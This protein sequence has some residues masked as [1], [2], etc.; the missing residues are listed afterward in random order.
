M[1][2]ISLRNSL[3]EALLSCQCVRQRSIRDALVEQLPDDLRTRLIRHDIDRVDV[4]SIVGRCCDWVGGLD[5]LVEAVRG[6]EGDGS[7]PFQRVYKVYSQIKAETERITISDEAER[8]MQR[9][10]GG[11]R[12]FAS[13]VEGYCDQIGWKIAESDN[14]HAVLKF[15][16]SSGRSQTLLI[17]PFDSALEFSVPSALVFNSDVDLPHELST[18]LLLRNARSPCAFWTIQEAE[19]QCFYSCMYNVNLELMD[20][21]H[22]RMIVESLV[23]ECDALEQLLLEQ[24]LDE[25]SSEQTTRQGREGLRWLDFSF[26]R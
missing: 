13:L 16:M 11:Q 6:F 7:R 15:K 26:L 14:D 22:F 2:N 8:V 23:S 5:A 25:S 21:Q 12:D 19:N 18:L 24:L 3:V 4:I 10:E 17:V 9:R 20:A 1:E